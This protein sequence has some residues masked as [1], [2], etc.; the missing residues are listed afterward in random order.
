MSPEKISNFSEKNDYNIPLME[1]TTN[2][3]IKG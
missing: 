1:K 3:N 2:N